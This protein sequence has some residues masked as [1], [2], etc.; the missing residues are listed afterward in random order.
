MNY[1][2]NHILYLILRYSFLLKAFNFLINLKLFTMREKFS[3]SKR[4]KSF[5]HAFYGLIYAIRTQHNTWIHIAAV[6]LVI[7]AGVLL[8]VSAMEWCMLVFA[9]G[10]V[11]VAEL[12]NTAIE[13]FVDQQFPEYNKYAG[14]I[15]DIS[16][17]AVLMAAFTAAAI[18]L[19]IFLP[20]IY[21][22]VINNINL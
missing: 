4:Y 12:F 7:T 10:L 21:E 5:K 14:L 15:K 13:C 16:A 20:I 1:I 19:I 2:D 11:F 8:K 3:V 9:M 18:G 22:L 6:I 17:G